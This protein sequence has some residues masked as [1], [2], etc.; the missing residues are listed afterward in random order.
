MRVARWAYLLEEDPDFRRWYENTGRGSWVTAKARA[1]VLYRFVQLNGLTP[2][3]LAEMAASDLRGVE[4]LLMDF[5]SELHREGKSPGYSDNYMKTVKSWLKFNGVLL[6]RSINVGNRNHTP[7]LEDERVPT[8]DEL[9][10]IL[11]YADGRGRCS[12]AFMALAGLRPQVLGKI[13]GTD[14]LEVRDLPDMVVG[15]GEVSFSKVPTMVVVRSS[16]SKAKHK[17]FTFMPAEGCDYLKAYL[18]RRLA[19]GEDLGPGSAIITT[20]PGHEETGFRVHVTHG[21]GHVSTRTVTHGIRRAMRPR[22]KWRPYVLRAYFATQLL[23]AENNGKISNAYRKFFMGHKGDIE[24]RYTTNKGRL[25][26]ALIEDMRLRFANSEEYLLPRR[27]SGEDPV[28]TTIKTM[29]EARTIN[30]D[31]ERVRAFVLNKLGIEDVEVEVAMMKEA[32]VDDDE[33]EVAVIVGRLGLTM[34]DIT[35]GRVKNTTKIVKEDEL[36]DYLSDGWKID[37]PLP[38]GSIVIKKFTYY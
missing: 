27:A 31:D 21:S 13:D 32:G 17:Y 3:S 37:T 22:F 6:V 8:P 2:R 7:T 11:G 38:S 16:L 29:I 5:V 14:G 24:A 34:S 36:T 15:G 23:I 4:D 12:V 9:L 25:P 10:Q 1:R 18:E 19:R 35:A 30:L 33:A 28:I 20:K 26:E